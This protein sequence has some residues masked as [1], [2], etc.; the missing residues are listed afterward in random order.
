[1]TNKANLQARYS[2]DDV[3][4]TPGRIAKVD[5]LVRDLANYARLSDTDLLSLAKKSAQD[6]TIFE[7][8]APFFWPS[9]ISN[10]TIDA[11]FTHMDESSLRNYA[12]DA[13]EGV[14]FQNSHRTRELPLGKSLRGQFIDSGDIKTVVSDAYTVAGMQINEVSTD[15][16]II[17]VRAGVIHDVSIGFHGGDFL[18]DICNM[19]LFDWDCPHIPGCTYE[20]ADPNDDNKKSPVVCTARVV[21]AHLSEYSAVYDGACPGAA[22]LKAMQEMDGGRLT[23]KQ[24]RLLEDRYASE[25]IRFAGSERNW[26]GSKFPKG[27]QSDNEERITDMGDDKKPETKA[28]VFVLTSDRALT[29]LNGIL[30]AAGLEAIREL[31][32]GD[33]ETAL[34]DNVRLIV[35]ENASLKL[36]AADGDVYRKDITD[37]ANKQGVRA[38]GETF[39]AEQYTD[40]F[41]AAPIASIRQMSVAW[42]E[43]GDK[44][45]EPGRKL[46]EDKPDAKPLDGDPD[47]RETDLDSKEPKTGTV[48]V[49]AES[50]YST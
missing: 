37:E 42:K 32:T 3:F 36:R 27:E 7:T 25:R 13:T 16:F 50:F 26:S 34:V 39:K 33:D 38:L 29:E 8:N 30:K 49:I 40:M 5:A 18:C 28:P 14:S 11:Y 24:A 31:K 47:K 2:K 10:D 1:M 45:I 19:S 17:G 22:I 41:K 9:M 4:A 48:R 23:P 6:P 15:Q 44:R 35:A 43:I 21:D 46:G 20:I 12:Q